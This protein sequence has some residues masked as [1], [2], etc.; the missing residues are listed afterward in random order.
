[1]PQIEVGFDI[2]A[3]GIL[4]VTAK[5]KA[6]GREQAMQ[7]MP[8][9]GLSEEEIDNMVSDAER[10]ANEDAKRKEGVEA[11]NI[12]DSAIYSAER[13]LADNQ[14]SLPEAQ[15]LAVQNQIDSAKSALEGGDLAGIQ[16]A[17]NQLQQVMR[18]TSSR[19][20]T[21]LHRK[22]NPPQ[23]ESHPTKT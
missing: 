18:C 15:Q 23:M 6:T 5:D 7:I 14:E 13:F 22:G 16:E 20:R 4:N 19:S 21:R 11:K 9:S 3:D 10:Y 1:V 2:N 12:A 8:S 17:T